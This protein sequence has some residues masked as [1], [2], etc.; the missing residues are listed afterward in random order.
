MNLEYY[1]PHAAI[2][3]TNE[4]KIEQ[5]KANKILRAYDAYG[6][7]RKRLIYPWEIEIH[8]SGNCPFACKECSYAT[9][10]TGMK[11][12]NDDIKSIF[13]IVSEDKTHCVFFSGGGDPFAWDG[14][15]GLLN[16]RKKY[17][18]CIPIG[19]STNLLGLPKDIDFKEIDFYQI[20]I[21]GYDEKSYFEQIGLYV[22]GIFYDNL[23]KVVKSAKQISLKLILNDYVCN[24]LVEFLNFLEEF[25]VDNI[26]FKL[27]QNFL[28]NVD[29][30]S[31]DLAGVLEIIKKHPISHKF[32]IINNTDDQLYYQNIELDCCHIIESGLYCLIRENGEVFPCIASTY[33]DFNSIGNIK[34]EPLNVILKSE[35][36][37]ENLNNKMKNGICPLK[38]CRHYRLNKIIQEQYNENID[39]TNIEI[40]IML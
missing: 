11:L 10:H 32:Q 1:I 37:F 19:V 9:R 38:A 30:K 12:S 18:P 2:I 3:L 20:H 13:S 17:I 8:L 29:C 7:D 5:F 40:P 34:K 16:L 31:V 4:D 35:I 36:D 22:F 15:R 25:D 39:Y 27:E 14:W 28:M 24:H 26:I 21:S 23:V 33:S 6:K